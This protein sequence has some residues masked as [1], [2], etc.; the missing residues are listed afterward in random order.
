METHCS[1]VLVFSNKN[2][3]LSHVHLYEW[4]FA[5]V[6]FKSCF[7][8]V[9]IRE[10]DSTLYVGLACAVRPTNTNFQPLL[11]PTQ[12]GMP[13]ANTHKHRMSYFKST[14]TFMG[15]A[16][17][18]KCFSAPFK[19]DKFLRFFNIREYGSTL[20]VGLARAVSPTNTNFWLPFLLTRLQ[21]A[22]YEDLAV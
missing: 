17:R 2:K 7:L 14:L 19:K 11:L 10:Y 12:A 20:Y 5:I 3:S 21:E 8:W 6:P 13:Y 22:L 4:K 16:K 15:P 1:C 9:I 18:W